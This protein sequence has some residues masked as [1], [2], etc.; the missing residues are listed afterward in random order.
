MVTFKQPGLFHDKYNKIDKILQ[1][2]KCVQAPKLQHFSI[3]K[4]IY[5]N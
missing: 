3:L 4:M 1:L 2:L 5:Y